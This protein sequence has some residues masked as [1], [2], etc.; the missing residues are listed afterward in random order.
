MPNEAPDQ[1]PEEDHASSDRIRSSAAGTSRKFSASRALIGLKHPRAR[2]DPYPLLTELAAEGPVLVGSD[3]IVLVTGYEPCAEVLKSAKWGVIDADW[4][5]ARL[6]GWRTHRSRVAFL[7]TALGLNGADH[8]RHRRC[9]IPALS[10]RAIERR[11]AALAEITY[12]ELH[13]FRAGLLDADFACAI[14]DRLPVFAVCEVLGL[15]LGD[16]DM[17]QQWAVDIASCHEISPSPSVLRKA[18]EA[19]SVLHDYLHGAE[20]APRGLLAKLRRQENNHPDDIAFLITVILL[21][22]GWE[23]TSFLLPNLVYLLH[24]Y[25]DQDALLRHDRALIPRAVEETL[26]FESPTLLDTRVALDD[27]FIG[28]HPFR[29]GQLAYILHAMANRDPAIFD[30][31]DRFEVRRDET[32]HLAFGYG[33]HLCIGAQL[34]RMEAQ[35]FLEAL[36]DLFPQGL[37]VTDVEYRPGLA[38]RGFSR[39]KVAGAG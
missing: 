33:A 19:T 25:P 14:A 39:F 8:Q 37:Q 28:G 17:L 18:D 38:F 2:R 22:A 24:R 1:L 9:M 34:A 16:A 26:R 29:R 23:T 36:F 7:G 13:R 3:G 27:T 15:D 32:D 20:A 5:D 6:Q 4:S 11:R 21:T 35:V 12:R 10:R 30:E 31:P